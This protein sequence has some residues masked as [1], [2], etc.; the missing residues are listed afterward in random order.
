MGFFIGLIYSVNM[1]KNNIKIDF[2]QYYSP[3]KGS[4]SDSVNQG[5]STAP[6]TRQPV[7]SVVY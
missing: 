3:Y 5:I 2:I 7:Q 6:G 4:V 1:L